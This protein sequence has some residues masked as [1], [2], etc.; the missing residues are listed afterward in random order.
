M[1][2]T[3]AT[4]LFGGRRLVVPARKLSGELSL[5]GDKSISHR[6]L[7]LAAL[8]TGTSQIEGLSPGA[9]VAATAIALRAMGVEVNSR[10]SV[11]VVG[12]GLN[13]LSRPQD[14]LYCGNSG[15]TMRLL[16]GLLAAQPFSSRLAGDASLCR[17]PMA[18]IIEPLRAMGAAVVAEGGDGRAPL[19]IAGAGLLGIE[20]HSPVASAQVKSCLLLAALYARGRTTLYEP[21]LSRDHS[22]RML[23]SFGVELSRFSGGVAL[24]GPQQPQAPSHIVVPGDISAAAFF[25]VAAAIR[26]GSSLWLRRVGINETRS[27]VLDVLERAGVPVQHSQARFE[28]GEPMADLYIEGGQPVAFEVGPDLV[29]RL[30]DELPV[31]A[32]LAGFAVGRSVISGAAELRAKES[33]RI[34]STAKLLRVLG[35]AVEERPDG[36]VIEGRAGQPFSGGV[37]DCMGDHRLA[38][39]AAIAALAAESSIEISGSDAVATS[40]PGFFE[41]LESCCDR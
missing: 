37:V 6:A 38:M 20:H 40:F 9:D 18:R 4:P 11:E 27:G 8:S 41:Q 39:S 5:P 16:A 15:T 1:T 21:H 13:G 17:R 34:A 33:D 14:S 10:E 12:V 7:I 3:S 26:P 22:E 25:L 28:S 23:A 30:I 19:A 35:V 31:L 24:E 29:P 36:L 32:V 2:G